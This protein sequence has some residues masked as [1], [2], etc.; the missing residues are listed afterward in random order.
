MKT[1]QAAKLTLAAALLAALCVGKWALGNGGPFVV[2]APNGDPAAKGVLARL[3]PTLKPAREERLRVVKEDLTI[4]F[5]PER[6]WEGD[7]RKLPP[8]VE[9]TAAYRIENPT[10]SEVQEDFG[11]PILR[12]VY[13]RFGM[14][15]AAADVG[16]TVD[17]EWS[18]PTM[19]SNS[20]IY[21]IIRQNAR[22]VIEKGITADPE[23]ALWTAA[24]RE[25]RGTPRGASPVRSGNSS[26]ADGGLERIATTGYR[27]ARENLKT[28]LTGSRHWNDRDAALFIEYASL[29]FGTEAKSGPRDRW[30]YWGLW[31][32]NELDRIKQANL[33]PL[34]AIGEQKATQ[35]FAQLAARFDKDAGTAYEAIFSAWGGD[36]RERAVDIETGQLRPRELELPAP[37][38]F[39][40]R[41][42]LTP[43]AVDSRLTADPTV[44]AR[45]DY[46]DPNA[47]ISKAERGSCEA[48]LRNLPVVFTFAPMNLLHYQVKFPPNATRT[49]T[50]TYRQHA[51]ADTRGTGSYQLAYVLHPAT[52]WNEFGPIHVALHV[53]KG[54]A[55]KA[56]AAIDKTGEKPASPG[57]SRPGPTP[58]LSQSDA[59]TPAMS[60]YQVTLTEPAQK[61]GELFVGIDKAAWDKAFIAT[62][63]KPDSPRQQAQQPSQ[64]PRPAANQQRAPAVQR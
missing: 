20:V 24:V 22:A 54:I 43:E 15:G 29:K 47:K 50:V 23:L 30:D 38:P 18:R 13:L 55:C 53:P 61:S 51:Y 44:Y 9:V 34:A 33:G 36:V 7:K 64:P 2:K 59:P 21:G 58:E 39:D 16:V 56:S 62:R 11:F 19:I 12:G 37:K 31:N 3:D 32:P 42:G 5:V 26:G 57:S 1:A 25:V 41:R 14:A 60:V 52:L 48:I 35:L 4:R 28:Y 63:P 45:I 10:G 6:Q 46:L 27:P 40:P 49:V 17:K 8:L